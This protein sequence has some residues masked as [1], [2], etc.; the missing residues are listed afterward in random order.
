MVLLALCG[1]LVCDLASVLLMLP[2]AIAWAACQM[3]TA[4]H[5]A[6]SVRCRHF[7]IS[8]IYSRDLM[9]TFCCK[10]LVRAHLIWKTLHV[11]TA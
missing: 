9:W 5:S 10:T 1:G 8:K 6:Q 11:E 4:A 3:S 2:R 7:K